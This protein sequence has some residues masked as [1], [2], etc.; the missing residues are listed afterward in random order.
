MDDWAARNLP[1]VFLIDFELRKPVAVPLANAAEEGIWF[2]TP[3][4][5]NSDT[6]PTADHVLFEK[7]PVSFEEYHR[8]YR[9]VAEN[10]HA[11]NSFLLN[12]TCATPVTTNLSLRQI[13]HSA[14]AKYRLL[15]RNEFVCFSPETFIEINGNEISTHPMKGT[16]DASLPGAET[17]L[18]NDFKEKAEHNTI[19]DLLRNDLNRIARRVKLDKFRYLDRLETNGKPLLQVS[20][21]IS[22]SLSNNWPNE[23][24]SLLKKLLPAGSVSG[25]PKT[26][27]VDIIRQAENI[28]RGYY[29]GIFGIYKDRTVDAAVLIRYI[30]KNQ[31][32]T[33]YRSGGGVTC[34]SEAEKEYQEMIDK[35]YLPIP[36][37]ESN[38]TC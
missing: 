7:H 15:F 10:I 32:G 21:K 38:T 12:Y 31:W 11:G 22:G 29:T 2:D 28:P 34:F 25:A 33:F 35:V 16:I 17:T 36:V 14:K 1:F 27:T 4:I 8:G 6:A 18:L 23:F 30:E 5:R 20:S 24:S 13:F 9:I 37:P 3:N 19:V 26:K